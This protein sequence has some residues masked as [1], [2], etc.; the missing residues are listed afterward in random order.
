[1][2]MFVRRGHLPEREE[3]IE[4]PWAVEVPNS[5]PVH[6][7]TEPACGSH[8]LDSLTPVTFFINLKVLAVQERRFSIHMFTLLG[9]YIVFC[10][11]TPT[12]TWVRG[13]RQPRFFPRQRVVKERILASSTVRSCIITTGRWTQ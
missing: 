8:P 5:E 13:C 4:G 9:R 7:A 3:P 11:T 12:L 6:Y 1:M 2:T 10:S